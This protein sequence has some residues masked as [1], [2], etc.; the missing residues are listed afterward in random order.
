[1]T[2]ADKL[3]GKLLIV[4]GAIDDNVHLQNSMQLISKLQDEGKEFELMIYPGNRHGIRGAK[5]KH[6]QQLGLNFW[7]KCFDLKKE[8]P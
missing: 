6:N 1:M 2:H 5:G 7:R 8:Q 3:K 4:H